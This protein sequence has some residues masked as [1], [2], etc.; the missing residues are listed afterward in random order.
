MEAAG[1]KERVITCHDALR[2]I[3]PSCSLPPQLRPRLVLSPQQYIALYRQ[4]NT[5]HLIKC[6]H[7]CPRYSNKD[8]ATSS[9]VRAKHSLWSHRRE[10]MLWPSLQLRMYA[11]PPMLPCLL[12][13]LS[14]CVGRCK[15]LEVVTYR[16]QRLLRSTSR[17]PDL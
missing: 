15:A 6:P 16:A 12:L 17:C 8:E 10:T 11:L 7:S 9:H 2:S 3:A 4:Q 5:Q 14:T 1:R 13:S